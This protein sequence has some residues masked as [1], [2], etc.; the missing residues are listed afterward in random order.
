MSYYGYMSV[1]NFAWITRI[2]NVKGD[3]SYWKQWI[4]RQNEDS[5]EK[6]KRKKEEE[7]RRKTT[8]TNMLNTKMCEKGNE[9]EKK[10]R[11]KDRD[12]K[13]DVELLDQ[14]VYD[15]QFMILFHVFRFTFH[16]VWIQSLAFTFY[17]KSKERRV[18]LCAYPGYDCMLW[19][20]NTWTLN[21]HSNGF[22]FLWSTIDDFFIFLVKLGSNVCF[23]RLHHDNDNNNNTKF[24]ICHL[25]VFLFGVCKPFVN[26]QFRDRK[27]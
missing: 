9:N 19:N 14:N 10:Q 5:V 6:K 21:T 27:C 23:H 12:K 8:R 4:N 24:E 20:S 22:V 2:W 26:V 11:K 25:F 17:R 1:I 13:K 3:I 18:T 16:F 7:K 15:R